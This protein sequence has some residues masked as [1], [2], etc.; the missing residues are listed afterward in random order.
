MVTNHFALQLESVG[1][2][3]LMNYKWLAFKRM[4][5]FDKYKQNQQ[6]ASQ[7]MK[8]VNA[9]IIGRICVTW[10]QRKF[11]DMFEDWKRIARYETE[12]EEHSAILEMQATVRRVFATMRVQILR[13]HRAATTIQCSHRGNGGRQM[14]E[15]RREYLRM[16]YAASVIE[17]AWINLQV[18]RA[19][20]KVV[21]DKK[22]AKAARTIQG[23]WRARVA[24][25][26]VQMMKEHRNMECS[27]LMIQ[28]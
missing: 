11:A 6:H 4:L 3:T 10:L 8:T 15:A 16:K 27:C 21:R 5:S 19:A 1:K 20:K 12:L 22:L 28:R 25:S 18:I 23:M 26:R 7:F 17:N 14:A 9:R 2:K 24:R 13:E